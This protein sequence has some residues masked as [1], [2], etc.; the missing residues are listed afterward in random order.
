MFDGRI[1]IVGFGRGASRQSSGAS[2]E[3][4]MPLY[5]YQ[6]RE[7]QSQV[8]LLVHGSTEPACPQCG[9]RQMTKLLSVVAAPARDGGLG[10]APDRTGGA[11]GPSCG[12]HPHG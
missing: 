4:K 7:C 8:E 10:T 5:E 2:W 9:S 11:C 6:C 12:C 3:D 1:S